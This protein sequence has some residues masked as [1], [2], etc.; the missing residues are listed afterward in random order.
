MEDEPLPKYT[1][2]DRSGDG[3]VRTGLYAKPVKLKRRMLMFLSLENIYSFLH[4]E[5][6]ACELET[7]VENKTVLGSRVYKSNF[8]LSGYD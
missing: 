8:H 1:L 3:G 2:V 4:I 5:R 7:N 6:R